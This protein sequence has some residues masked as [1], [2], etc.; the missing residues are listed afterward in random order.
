M[1]R[2]D[3]CQQLC[4]QIPHRFQLHMYPPASFTRLCDFSGGYNGD[5]SSRAIKGDDKLYQDILS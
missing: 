5:R 2:L 3:L 1:S 4:L